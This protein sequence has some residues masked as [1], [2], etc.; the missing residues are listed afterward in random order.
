VLRFKNL[1]GDRDLDFLTEGIGETA[2]TELSRVPGVRLIERNQVDQ[3]IKEIDFG[4]TRYVDQTTAA[5]LGRIAGAEVAIQGGYQR[6][7]SDIRVTAR[8]VRIATGEI[9]DTMT[10][11]RPAKKLFDVQDAVAA[12]LRDHVGKFSH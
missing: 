3:A 2:L 10:L 4:Q 12:D 7:G 6:A 9:L 5:V 1:G 11:T 8:L